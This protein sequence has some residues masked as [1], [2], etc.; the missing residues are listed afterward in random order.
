MVL[1][2]GQN[3]GRIHNINI[4]NRSFERAEQFKYLGTN[5][6]NQNLFRK[7]LRAVVSRGMLAIIRCRTFCLPICCS[8]M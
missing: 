8:E 1:S 5:L 6:T 7:K 4:D 3:A 2:R